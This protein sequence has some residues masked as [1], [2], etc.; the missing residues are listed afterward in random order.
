MTFWSRSGAL[1]LRPRPQEGPL[2]V[3]I[4]EAPGVH[5]L[6]C[7]CPRSPAGNRIWLFE[8]EVLPWISPGH[9]QSLPVAR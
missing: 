2:T 5:S 1:L 6:P 7:S 4:S 8:H 9:G 3:E